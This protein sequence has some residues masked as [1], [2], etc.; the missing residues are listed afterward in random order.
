MLKRRFPK[1]VKTPTVLQMEATECGAASLSMILSYFGRYEPL[2]K[3]REACCINRNG[4]KA[5][6]IVNAAREYGLT[7]KGYRILAPD[8]LKLKAPYILFWEF[9]HFLVYEGCSKDGKKVYLN[10]PAFGPRVLSYEEFLGMYTGV[11]IHFEPNEGF[12]KGGKPQN[13]FKKIWPLVKEMK[14]FSTTILWA[15]LLLTFPG[16][17][18]PSLTQ[19]FVDK[20]L[21]GNKEWLVPVL[22]FFCLMMFLK[23]SLVWIINSVLR[24]ASLQQSVNKTLEMLNYL[25]R[26]PSMFF[27]QRASGDIQ[28]RVSLNASVSNQVFGAF[29]SNIIQF[30][31][32]LFFLIMMLCISVKLTLLVLLFLLFDVFFLIFISK[33]S[34]TLYQSLLNLKIKAYSA[35][36]EGI[37]LIESLRSSGCEN[38]MNKK[39][40]NL[41]RRTN[42]KAKQFEI[43]SV[44]L[45]TIPNFLDKLCQILILCFGAKQVMDSAMTFGG[46]FAFQI[47][48]T[49]FTEP[50]KQILMSGAQLQVL[51]AD[52]DRVND[53]HKYKQQG[54]FKEDEGDEEP[55]SEFKSFELKNITFGYA[56][57]EEPLIKDFSLKLTPGKRIS[58]VGASG[59]GKSTLARVANGTLDPWKGE[60]L[61]NSKP[62]KEYTK[63]QFY[64]CVGT[65]DQNITLFSGSIGENLTLFSPKY[66][67]RDLTFALKDAKIDEDLLQRGPVLEQNV[68]EE[69]HNFSGGQR[70][71]LEIARVLTY[72]TPVI[73]L[74]EATSSLDP[75]TELEI[76]EAIRNRG[77]ACIVIAHR[78]STVRDSDEIIMLDHGDVVERGTH[79]ELMALNGKYASFM[80][81]EDVHGCA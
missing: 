72:R 60:V 66:D 5:S 75:I 48:V 35:I 34:Q 42:A 14:S 69:G 47:L 1:R 76:N 68:E 36:I 73:I 12:K 27:M 9:N 65:V 11:A 15:G 80:R 33:K 81:L 49:S 67:Q 29:S 4:S 31:T 8:L 13:I 53:V 25:F 58:I 38:A 19:I 46:L 21:S 3:L 17:I 39:W 55:I 22:C 50:F 2:E 64:S 37:S 43:T 61:L 6:L 7:S 24:K 74:D 78:L 16:I 79:E 41:I 40:V 56:K 10:D 23:G 57:A 54:T 52:I 26:L 70:Q 44:Y 59:S 71:R 63:A 28:K 77:C 62:L 32:A 18:I 20:I 51:K 45:N 30:F